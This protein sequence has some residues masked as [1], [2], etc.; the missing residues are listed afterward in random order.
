MKNSKA[1]QLS[2]I[3]HFLLI[4]GFIVSPYLFKKEKIKIK[5]F[6]AQIYEVQEPPEDEPPTPTIA[7]PPK[8]VPQPKKP[9]LP[10]KKAKAIYGISQKSLTTKNPTQGVAVKS[11]NTLAKEVDQ[12]IIT[13]S[14]GALPIP[15]PNFKLSKRPRVIKD[16]TPKYPESLKAQGKEGLVILN[17]LIDESGQV[18][19]VQILK[20]LENSLDQLAKK[21]MFKFL[22]TPA[23]LNGKKVPSRIKYR[24]NFKLK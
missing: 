15:I 17:V 19:G 13:S 21:S 2:F 18:R 14:E 20:S 12:K 10:S 6:Q 23:E 4:C 24:M 8:E 1:W 5:T 22:F 16:A 3:I 7:L 9:K 11:G